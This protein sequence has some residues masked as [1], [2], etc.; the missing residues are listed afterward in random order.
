MHTRL[1]QQA[2]IAVVAGL[3]FFTNLGGP[4]LWDDDEP[5]N[6]QCAREMYERGD[7]IAPTFN[8]EPRTDKPA[9][10]YWLMMASYAVFG[11]TEFAARF[12]SAVLGVGTVILTYHLGR[13]LFRPQVGL[14]AGLAM[15][16]NLM[17]GIA[18]R[19]ATPDSAL[20]FFTTLALLVYVGTM[21]GWR[22]GRFLLN[23]RSILSGEFAAAFPRSW[24]G[25]A[26]VYAPMSLALLAKGPVGIVLPCAGIG[27]FLLVSCVRPQA[28]TA[29]PERKTIFTLSIYYAR[30][31][32]A[33]TAEYA[34]WLLRAERAMWPNV[35][36]ATM[37]AI[38]LP[39]Y[40]W[41]TI[42]TGGDWTRSF[43]LTHNLDRYLHAMEGHHGS[44]FFHVV[45][46]VVCFFPWSFILPAA[47]AQLIR[48]VRTGDSAGAAGLLLM[49]WIAVWFVAFSLSGTK[50]PSYVLPAYPALAV[51]CGSWIADW[52]AAPVR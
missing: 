46:I 16:T 39:W 29:M 36:V 11:V 5:R 9:L 50:L 31:A 17:F 47:L 7:P 28:V 32:I 20:I 49:S 19:A 35:L 48:R 12:P 3:V 8:H 24:K 43:L 6:A 23:W 51:A 37:A 2:C 4:K 34:S 25:A 1:A 18:A 33:H 15:A 22:E 10:V 41:V 40:L 21:T 13:L 26:A 14:W 27:L 38:A 45:A 44:I 42:K 30:L 52:N